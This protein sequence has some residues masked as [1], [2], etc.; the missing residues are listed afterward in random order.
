MIDPRILNILKSNSLD[1]SYSILIE[2]FYQPEFCNKEELEITVHQ[3]N[4]SF[5][6]IINKKDIIIDTL[7]NLLTENNI[8]IPNQ[9]DL[10][11]NN[12][13]S[14]TFTIG[15]TLNY[16]QSEGLFVSGLTGYISSEVNQ[17]IPSQSIEGQFKN[18]RLIFTNKDYPR[19]FTEDKFKINKDQIIISIPNDIENVDVI[20]SHAP[21][22]VSSTEY[23]ELFTFTP[24]HF[25]TIIDNKITIDI[26][27]VRENVFGGKLTALDNT[28]SEKETQI[29]SLTETLV[30][31]D[32]L[33]PEEEENNAAIQQQID[34]LITAKTKAE[35]EKQAILNK[36]DSINFA[37][38]KPFDIQMNYSYYDDISSSGIECINFDLQSEIH[39]DFI[40]RYKSVPGVVLTVDKQNKRYSS[41]DTVF[42]ID[43]DGLYNGVTIIFNNLKR[44]REPIDVN[45]IIIG[46]VVD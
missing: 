21:I 8:E 33:T 10:S 16:N 12:I 34:T 35:N 36:S 37:G 11:I 44:I 25:K 7:K 43:G 22:P 14:K 28:I 42:S 30:T 2:D 17:E 46:D 13:V 26:E 15:S 19:V 5:F 32:E 23:N 31:G 24:M 1:P 3:I 45:A 39:L 27:S 29:E 41:Y 4:P 6:D 38:A 20:L 40:K 18:K 9:N